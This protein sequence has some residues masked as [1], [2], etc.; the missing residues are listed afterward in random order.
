MVGFVGKA[1][2][3]AI[4]E[5]T[6]VWTVSRVETAVAVEVAV[7][8]GVV[9]AAVVVA[10]VVAVVAV[11]TVV[12]ATALLPP[13]PPPLAQSPVA[14]LGVLVSVS[15]ESVKR[16]LKV[17]EPK[18]SRI[19]GKLELIEANLAPPRKIP[20]L[21]PVSVRVIVSVLEVSLLAEIV[22][23]P[24]TDSAVEASKFKDVSVTVR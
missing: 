5:A 16:A 24:V 7:T 23:V 15:W 22:A 4:T 21:M 18:H 10:V 13:P 20:V 2:I 14:L 12:A 3:L 6:F 1:A 9:V 19:P 17:T 8:T 11:V